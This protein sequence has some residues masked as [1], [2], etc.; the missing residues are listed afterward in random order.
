MRVGFFEVASLL[1]LLG[2]MGCV[3][4]GNA[5]PDMATSPQGGP[6]PTVPLAFHDAVFIPTGAGPSRIAAGLVNAQ[7]RHVDLAVS[8]AGDGS[9]TVLLGDGR[10]GF[11]RGNC[12]GC[13]LGQKPQGVAFAS[14]NGDAFLDMV[15]ADSTLHRVSVLIGDG[16]QAFSNIRSMNL[17]TAPGLA[18]T[19][20]A[21]ADFD[22]NGRMDVVTSNFASGDLS[23][24]LGQNN[25]DFRGPQ[26]IGVG[27]L[28]A[29]LAAADFD[30]DGRMDLA[31]VTSGDEI[32]SVFRGDG[33]GG[34][35]PMSTTKV[36]GGPSGLA[37]GDLNRDGLPDVVV[38]S[39]TGNFATVLMNLG[40]GRL[41]A[42]P[43]LLVTGLEPSSLALADL[44]G[45]GNLDL[46]VANASDNRVSV[47]Q[48]AGGGSFT[49][50]QAL[51]IPDLNGDHARPIAIAVADLNEDAQ[52]DV[53]VANYNTNLLSVFLNR[54]R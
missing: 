49:A 2:T 51:P 13:T 11:T 47:F 40:G 23:I 35:A 43:T 53:V 20:L 17:S 6:R 10:G 1:S 15:L 33:S 25:G 12:P 31:V 9:V 30:R 8:A 22:G 7:D 42:D 34:L 52:P 28:A 29:D 19:S 32:V 36:P 45:D 48:G 46:V 18:P 39:S 54:T 27:P 24:F 3:P 41:K 21:V 4:V 26:V 44:D 14:I 38:A 50:Q 16:T 5:P 37:V